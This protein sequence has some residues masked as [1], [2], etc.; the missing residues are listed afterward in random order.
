[1][2]DHVVGLAKFSEYLIVAE[3]RRTLPSILRFPFT[4]TFHPVPTT[5]TSVRYPGLFR[6]NEFRDR[7][8]LT[9]D[10]TLSTRRF[11]SIG[12]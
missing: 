8:V 9:D 1:M 12:V 6:Q 11:T 4:E 2:F 7:F 3:V 5:G 10:A